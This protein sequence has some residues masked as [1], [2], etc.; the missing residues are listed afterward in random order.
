MSRE[1]QLRGTFNPLDTTFTVVRIITL[2]T[3]AHKMQ[4]NA[5]LISYLIATILLCPVTC[6]RQ[7]ECSCGYDS[8]ECA[9]VS[10][11]ACDANDCSDQNQQP[12]SGDECCNCFCDGVIPKLQSN[13]QD[14]LVSCQDFICEYLSL[15]DRDCIF[16]AAHIQTTPHQ[17]RAV[18]FPSA[19][20]AQ[21]FCA[22]TSLF[23]C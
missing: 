16:Q 18:H 2:D 3:K 13:S 12:D 19:C 7:L 11:C 17:G 22:I 21:Q 5:G 1:A 9:S 8:V 6:I 10:N 20:S 14:E 15:R 4:F 23:L